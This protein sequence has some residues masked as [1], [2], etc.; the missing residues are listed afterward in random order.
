MVAVA[1]AN[2]R[3]L[4]FPLH[5]IFARPE[6]GSLV[7]KSNLAEPGEPMLATDKLLVKA[8]IHTSSHGWLGN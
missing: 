1:L 4:E 5:G 6:L 8:A 2:Q 3:L 7:P